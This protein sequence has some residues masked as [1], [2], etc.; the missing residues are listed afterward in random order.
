MSL[1]KL[2]LNVG[3]N[4]AHFESDMGRAARIAKT[5]SERMRKQVDIAMKA[6]TA[7]ASAAGTGLFALAKKFANTA[8]DIQ[9]MSQRLGVSTEFLSQMRHTTELTGVQF[10]SFET[11]LQ[12]MTRRLSEVANTGKGEAA[13]ALDILGISIKEIANLSPDKQMLLIADA[14]AKIPAQGERVRA[15]M[16]LFDTEG[17]AL[18][19]T[20]QNGSQ[21]ILD[22]NS[23]ADKLG[24][25][26]TQSTADSAAEFKNQ[27]TELKSALKGIYEQIAANL[28]PAFNEIIRQFNDSSVTDA[29]REWQGLQTTIASLYGA[30]LL[31]QGAFE[32]L[33][34]IAAATAVKAVQ[35]FDV[36]KSGTDV[37]LKRIQRGGLIIAGV[38]S[39][40]AA[41]AGDDLGRQ[42]SD[43]EQKTSDL[44]DTFA[45]SAVTNQSLDD[46]GDIFE[47]IYAKIDKVRGAYA[48]NTKE[49]SKNTKET[50][51]SGKSFLELGKNLADTEKEMKKLNSEFERIADSLLS[52]IEQL[53]KTYQE[54]TNT[55][56]DY[57]LA[58]S[59]NNELY[60]QAMELLDKLTAEYKSNKAEIDKNIQSKANELSEYEKLVKSLEDEIKMRGLS[61]QALLEYQA[62]NMLVMAGVK[63]DSDDYADKLKKILNLLNELNSASSKIQFV[64]GIV[65][66]LEG[67]A[68]AFEVM[69]DD[70]GKGLQQLSSSMTSL[71]EDISGLIGKDLLSGALGNVLGY[72][73][74]VGQISSFIDKI[75]GGKLFGT[76]WQQESASTN[77]VI[78]SDGASGT[79]SQTNVRQRS[80][81]RGRQWETITEQLSGD[82]LNAINQLFE[83]IQDAFISTAESVG[84]SMTDIIQGSFEQTF[85]ENGDL[86]SSVSE[87]LGRTYN[88]TFEQFGQ[89]LLA[90]NII[91]VLDDVTNMVTGQLA[92]SYRSS[93][94][95]LLEFADYA[96]RAVADMQN[97][98]A[99]LDSLEATTAIVEELG[100][101]NETLTE[102]YTRLQAS[103]Q[104]YESA[105]ETMGMSFEIARDDLVRFAA[106]IADAAGGVENAAQ[107]WRGYFQTFYTEAE[108]LQRQLESA[109]STR[110]LELSDIGL[111]SDINTEQFRNLFEQ[112]L[113]TLSADAI[114]QWLEAANAIGVVIDLE[115]QLNA[116]RDANAQQLAELIGNI[117]NEIENM[118]L[119]PFALQ[120]KDIRKQFE[121]NIASAKKLGAGEKELAMIQAYATRQIQQAIQA[122][123][124]DIGSAFDN[125]YGTQ[126]DQINQ[127]IALLEQQESQINNVANAQNNLYEQ[128][129]A[130]IQN[131]QSFVD[132]LLLNEQLSPLNPMEQLAEAQR[133]FA[134]MLALAQG[135]DVTAM[136]ALPGLAQTLLGF[137][138]DVWASSQNYVDLFDYVTSS[139]S[140]LGVTATQQ[141]PQQTI[142][143]QNAQM[144]EL[145]AQRNELEAQS[146]Y[147]AAL[148]IA[149]SIR[150]W[151]SVSNESFSA[152][153]E[154]LGIPLEQFLGDL[155]VNLD[156]LTQETANALAE[157]AQLLGVEL[158]DLANSVGVALGDLADDQSMLND[159]LENTI[160]QLPA[161][162]AGDLQSMLDAIEQST[163]AT[164]REELL[165]T[166]VEYIGGL[167]QSQADL[168]APYFDEI[169]PTTDAQSQIALMSSID[170]SNTQIADKVSTLNSDNNAKSDQI[171]DEI[172]HLRGEQSRTADLMQQLLDIL[173]AA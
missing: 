140:G 96:T 106:D 5:E 112:M 13:P 142:I 122:L 107:L 41:A 143:G 173:R 64:S 109:L 40:T 15:A 161:G 54:Q 169:D 45:D 37:F 120:L 160:S 11:A 73:G 84:S 87:I 7:G 92:E 89:R 75:T 88:E 148:E 20:L 158:T 39:D 103:T 83:S 131:I 170:T 115:S 4:I 57:A 126:L 127:Q 144:I 50:D 32:T 111:S 150:E 167:S 165:A 139:L 65:S 43:L 154:R 71:F 85:D 114:V 79:S 47:E 117:N 113:P 59:E 171:R 125:L 9:K 22:M 164:D 68:D 98:F 129:L 123:E 86:V 19:Q 130:A 81:F 49:Q 70:I 159:A 95:S 8:D 119:S 56:L 135:G 58:N 110:D 133:Q 153:A 108:L 118:G 63:A 51:K 74:I 76:D 141:D 93:A 33:G 46:I 3:A 34:K 163:D 17:V 26:I 146:R 104:L 62:K 38:F 128:Q 28:L 156:E 162:I 152:L 78:G 172:I 121:A 105:L 69:G 18:V 116:E 2:L 36:L 82:A 14:M 166:M 132:G 35:G 55:I 30:V 94:E 12:R 25:T 44:F 53:D 52:P 16:K 80:L 24:R 147:E 66:G 31:V 21:A 48:K 10:K 97:G 72:I 67:V 168:L 99:L 136:N 42:I 101:G 23:Q 29:D 124:N 145:L 137:G 90:E 27:M 1:G 134:E 151:A 149:N 60:Q 100:K 102:T 138:Q 157:T 77:Y 155:G 6:I 61:G 91:A